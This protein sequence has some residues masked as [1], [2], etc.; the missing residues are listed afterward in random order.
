MAGYADN[1]NYANYTTIAT[2]MNYTRISFKKI[3]RKKEYSHTPRDNAGIGR[4]N[5]EI[6]KA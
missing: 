4:G 2:D 1:H 3:L 5:I 6:I